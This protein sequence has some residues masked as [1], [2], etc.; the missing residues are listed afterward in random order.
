[1]SLKD[2]HIVFI[3]ASTLLSVGFAFWNFIQYRQLHDTLHLGALLVSVMVAIGL[4]FYEA[5]FIQKTK[6]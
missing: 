3:A 6:T 5:S 1:M 4:V 2:F